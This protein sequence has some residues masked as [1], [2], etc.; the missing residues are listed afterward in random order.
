MM[1]RH[2]VAI[3]LASFLVA[4]A[5]LVPPKPAEGPDTDYPCGVRGIS[6]GNGYCCWAHE[7]CIPNT[8]LCRN[9]GNELHVGSARDDADVRHATKE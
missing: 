5:L 9:L 2:I 1:M 8:T 7:A 4:C 3:W 6:C